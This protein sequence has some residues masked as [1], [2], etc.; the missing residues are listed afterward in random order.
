MPDWSRV[1]REIAIQQAEQQVT[2]ESGFDTVRRRYLR[3]LF[4]HTGRNVIAYYSGFLSKP[5]IESIEINDEDKNGL[6]LC[7]HKMDRGKG[8][9]LI[10]HTPGGGIAATESLVDYL[11]QMFGNDIR[12]IVPQIAMSAGTII[13]CSCR[14]IV[15]SKHSNLGPVDPQFGAIAAIGVLLEI[16]KAFEEIKADEKAA[17]VWQPI[18]SRLTPSFVQQCEWAVARSGEFLRDMLRRNMFSDLSEIDREAKVQSVTQ[19]L[20]PTLENRGHSQHFHY[21]DCEEMQL[22]L[23]SLEKDQKLQ[24]LVLTIHHCYMH[25]LSNT[26]ALKIIEN[27]LG[28]AH[29]KSQF[30]GVS[31]SPVSLAPSPQP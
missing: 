11:R 4:S 15:M 8:L 23:V 21:A 31:P 22:K 1:L 28:K 5:R 9:D 29:I 13:A 18:L 27:H 24:D 25:S 7:V 14:E 20:I 30:M 16:K 10:L 3:R 2:A 12:A 26:P 19:R 6:M 17:L